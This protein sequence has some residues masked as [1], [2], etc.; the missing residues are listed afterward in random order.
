MEISQLDIQGMTCASCV[1]H[2]EKAIKTVKG[3]EI[4]N[5]NLATETATVSFDPDLA[6]L[7]TILKS[8][9]ASGY[10]AKI[11]SS[12]SDENEREKERSLRRLRNTTIL[13]IL[14][15]A[16]LVVS[17]IAMIIDIPTLMFLHDPALQLLLAA[18]VQFVIGW[19]FYKAAWSSIKAGSPGMD[20]LVALGTSAAFAY[21]VFNGFFASGLGIDGSGLY[22]EASA[23]IISLVLL[24]RYFEA[25]AKGRTGKA[26][27]KLINLQPKTARVERDGQAI[28][29]PSSDVAVGDIVLVRPGERIPVDGIIVSG[30]S[31]L[32]ESAITGESLPV[33]KGEGDSVVSGSINTHGSFRFEAVRVGRE[34]MLS[35]IIAVVEEAQGSKAPIQKLADKVAS[36]FVP[37][38]LAIAAVT[39]L[40]WWLGSGDLV[41]GIISAVAVLV[42]ACPCALGLATPTAIMV[43][44]G[45]GAQRGILIKN[46]EILQAAGEIDAV[47]LDKTG[48]VTRGKPELQDI[49]PAPGSDLDRGGI[50]RI[51][52]SLEQLS[53]HPLARAIV[54]A[55][56]SEGLAMEEAADF[57]AHPGKGISGQVGGADCII[58]TSAFMEERGI[59]FTHLTETK[60]ELEGRG[61]SVVLLAMNGEPAGM[62]AIAD[63][64]KPESPEGVRRLREAG[65]EVYMITGDNRG[66]AESIAAQA[67]IPAE[68]V[69]AEVLPEDKAEEV[70]KLQAAGY[71][72][73]MTGD[74]IND[75]PALASA[76]TGIAMGEGTDIAIESSDIT[77]IRGD[78]RDLSRSIALSRRTMAKIRQN[79][80]WAFLYN[81][82]GIPFAAL[83]L[84][85]PMIAGAAMAF[86]SVSVVTNSLLLK[87]ADIEKLPR[88][89]RPAKTKK[90][91]K[92]AQEDKS[93]ESIK[94]HVDG[95]SCNHCK[96][97]VENAANGIEAVTNAVVDLES[98]TLSFEFAE[99]NASTVK[100]AVRI[101]VK[102]AGYEP[103]A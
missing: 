32:D 23:V 17:M 21:S 33:E 49:I 53:E 29:I 77:L 34:S 40:W 60:T 93:M 7:E 45:L 95:M 81:C 58:G 78:L 66:T 56:A 65:I 76:D 19:R 27:K 5:V 61:A 82:I 79:L 3:V 13:S 75:A 20:V 101:A 89:R 4:A 63:R 59:G 30:G 14:L 46:G 88:R 103:R 41:Q 38:V 57:T 100:D 99:G 69:L 92:S 96:M 1:A 31:S 71:T 37:V 98:G 86:S 54:D 9:D 102:A 26:L 64:I 39:F 83:G 91:E 84:L 87:R 68:N 94:L 22:F 48:T 67:D 50:L 51:A 15:T 43:G 16:P 6:D 55:G 36:I 44:T 72:V 80:F 62:L 10:G 73:A 8:V 74:G 90:A 47:I 24:G 12:D 11:H 28:E 18:P 25:L 52:A 70:K 2:V 85:N 35:R 97:S 42:I